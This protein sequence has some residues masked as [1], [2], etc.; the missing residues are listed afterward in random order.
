MRVSMEGTRRIYREPDRLEKLRRW[1]DD[2]WD[3][4]L[5]SFEEAAHLEADARERQENRDHFPSHPPGPQDR[6]FHRPRAGLRTLHRGR[7]VVATHH[8]LHRRQDAVGIRFETGVGGVV[9]ELTAGGGEHIWAEVT[10]WDPPRHFV[11]NW[12]PRIDP[13]ALNPRS[14]LLPRRRRHPGDPSITAGNA[15][16]PK[17]PNSARLPRRLGRRLGPAGE[18][19]DRVVGVGV[20]PRNSPRFPRF[21]TEFCSPGVR[22]R[23]NG[24]IPAPRI[25]GAV[26]TSFGHR[27]GRTP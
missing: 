11:L 17:P 22:P 10:E 13:T 1:I 15:S 6:W 20:S 8:P 21:G 12:H 26:D 5:D 7:R 14:E 18:L 2:Q 3:Q 27:P 9:V 25:L 23:Q 16:K 19:R 24:R 4:V